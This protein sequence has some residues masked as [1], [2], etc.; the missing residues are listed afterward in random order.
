MMDFIVI[1]S[2]VVCFDMCGITNR[3]TWSPVYAGSH[4]FFELLFS[5][6]VERCGAISSSTSLFIAF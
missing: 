2:M 6:I 4:S 1:F 5:Q 3:P